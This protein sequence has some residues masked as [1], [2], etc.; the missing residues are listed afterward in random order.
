[1]IAHAPETTSNSYSAIVAQLRQLY[2]HDPRPWF[3]GFSGGKDSTLVAAFVFDIVLSLT[4][5]ELARN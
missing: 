3:V 1:M 5:R 4:A 2:L